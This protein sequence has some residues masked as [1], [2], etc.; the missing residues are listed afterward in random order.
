[1]C[2]RLKELHRVRHEGEKEKRGVP[3]Q[4]RDHNGAARTMLTRDSASLV[5]FYYISK[6]IINY[7]TYR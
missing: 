4:S 1:M 6:L 5:Y 3:E 2:L 7:T